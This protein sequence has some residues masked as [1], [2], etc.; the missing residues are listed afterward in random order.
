M[1]EIVHQH[2]AFAMLLQFIHH[3]LPDLLG[4]AHFEV[5]GIHV[6]GEDR[7]VALTEIVDELLRLP[8]HWEAEIGCRRP[9]DRPAHGADALLDLV[10]GVVLYGLALPVAIAPTLGFRQTLVTPGMR[11]DGMPGRGHL[12]EDAG[13]VGGVQA[14]REEDRLG[15][16]CGERGEHRLRILRPGAI[17]ECKHYLAFAQEIIALEM[18]EPKAWAPSSV[19]LDHPCDP[20]SIGV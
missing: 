19:N 20:Q 6:S 7:D 10:L 8:Q 18:L 9:A 14:D 4:L 2:D 3:R 13:L 1:L 17:V 16:V 11:A 15:A 5:E 12:L